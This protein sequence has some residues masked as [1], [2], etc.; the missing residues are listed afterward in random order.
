VRRLHFGESHFGRIEKWR[1]RI[2]QSCEGQVR[3]EDDE[4]LTEGMKYHSHGRAHVINNDVS[5]DTWHSQIMTSVKMK[6]TF[7]V[8]VNHESE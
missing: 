2:T 3:S 7:Q 8:R 1:N 5:K 4:V 6:S